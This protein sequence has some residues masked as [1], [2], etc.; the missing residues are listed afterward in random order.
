MFS[1]DETAIGKI[2]NEMLSLIYPLAFQKMSTISQKYLTPDRITELAEV[3][4][5]Y[6]I[7]FENF[8]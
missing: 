3:R 6:F 1:R 7:L 2:F 4:N 8:S 5:N